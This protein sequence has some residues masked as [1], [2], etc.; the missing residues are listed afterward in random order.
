MNS[1]VA[2]PEFFHLQVASLVGKSWDHGQH[3]YPHLVATDTNDQP[4]LALGE[5]WPSKLNLLVSSCQMLRAHLDFLKIWQYPN[6]PKTWVPSSGISSY[7]GIK[8][9]LW[10]TFQRKDATEIKVQRWDCPTAFRGCQ[11]WRVVGSQERKL[12]RARLRRRIWNPGW[13]WTW[14]YRRWGAMDGFWA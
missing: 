9:R 5:G 1:W 3:L 14:I 11:S 7:L 12:E 2:P 13:A 8:H 10:R 4:S 6:Q